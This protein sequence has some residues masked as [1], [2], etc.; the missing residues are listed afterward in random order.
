MLFKSVFFQLFIENT[1]FPPVH[2]P[3]GELSGTCV[4]I[5]RNGEYFNIERHWRGRCVRFYLF[6]I[7]TP[8]SER[9]MI[10]TNLSRG[11]Y[12]DQHYFTHLQFVDS[13]HDSN[14]FIIMN[15]FCQYVAQ[16]DFNNQFFTERI[17]ADSRG[18]RKGTYFT[19]GIGAL[20]V[21]QAGEAHHLVA[22]TSCRQG[23][24]WGPCY[25]NPLAYHVLEY[26]YIDKETETTELK[27]I[28]LPGIQKL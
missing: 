20:H 12:D 19:A 10:M 16:F 4:S 8:R 6:K 27:S 3:Y 2:F 7:T 9:I 25:Y 14:S 23:R 17:I 11:P 24:R 21:Q 13:G 22:A 28:K 1:E 5:S 18:A 15:P 26:L